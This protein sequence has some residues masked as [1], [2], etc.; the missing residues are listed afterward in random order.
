VEQFAILSALEYLEKIKT[1]D[2]ITTIYTDRQTTLDKLEN[3]NIHS[4][5]VEEI[6]RKLMELE[7]RDWKITLRWVK[8]QVGIRGN[9]LAITLAKK[10]ATN[11]IIP[12]S[13]NKIP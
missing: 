10:A 5:I 3:S 2:K 13:Y 9:E 8:A 1:M 11:K 7:I 12:E 6:R 4:H